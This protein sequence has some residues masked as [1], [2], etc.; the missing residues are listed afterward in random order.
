MIL[1]IKF[2]AP[3]SFTLGKKT[4]SISIPGKDSVSVWELL[5]YVV[6][7]E[8]RFTRVAALERESI[9]N[10]LAVIVEG[11]GVVCDLDATVPDGANIVLMSPVS[12]G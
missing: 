10:K 6:K 12:G 1:N 11:K 5:E 2:L 9:F 8:P 3:Y 4:A 7:T